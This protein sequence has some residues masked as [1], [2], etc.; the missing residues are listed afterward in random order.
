VASI[1]FWYPDIPIWLLK[2]RQ[3]GE[4]STSEIEHYWNVKVYP[5]Q[6]KKLGWGFGKLDVVTETSGRRLMLV[7]SDTVF[8]GRVIDRLQQFGEELVVDKEDFSPQAIGVQFFPG[9]KLR[10]L[11]PKFAFPGY[12]FN[13]GQFVVTTGRIVKSDFEGLLHSEQRSVKHPGAFQK[14]EQG[15]FNYVVLRKVQ[16]GQ[17]TLHREPFMVWLGELS[18]VQHIRVEDLR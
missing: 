2:D 9:D 3:H 4:F 14:S 12:G 18:C 15:V 7:D 11:D 10:Q 8:T 13:T 5:S 16:Q 1:R 17:L 6:H